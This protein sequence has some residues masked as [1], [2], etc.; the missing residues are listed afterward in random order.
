MS[1]FS[2]ILKCLKYCQKMPECIRVLWDALPVT[3]AGMRMYDIQ[4][5]KPFCTT[6]AIFWGFPSQGISL[7]SQENSFA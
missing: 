2:Y 3:C 7:V 5:S 1:Y 4:R 6:G